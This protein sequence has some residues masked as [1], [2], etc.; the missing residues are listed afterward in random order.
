VSGD[1][2]DLLAELLGRGLRARLR[3]RGGSMRPALHDR[4][5]V[6]LAPLQGV[7]RPGTVVAA[8]RAGQLYLH[9]VVSASAEAAWLRG[10]AC[11]RGDGP[12]APAELLG[13]AVAVERGGR[14]LGAA[15][16]G[17]PVGR[18]LGLLVPLTRLWLRATG[19]LRGR[20][21]AAAPTAAPAAADAPPA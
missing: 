1:R 7:P 19:L 10:D 5:V 21:S 6:T 2:T 9:R 15:R 18:A 17:G 4:D 13:A 12:F 3:A 8:R 16:L 20:A 14:L 11:S